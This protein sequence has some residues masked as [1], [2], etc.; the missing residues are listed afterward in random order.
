MESNK[1]ELIRK[2]WKFHFVFILR[3]YIHPLLINVSNI[4]LLDRCIAQQFKNHNWLFRSS[5][6]ICCSLSNKYLQTAILK[7]SLKTTLDEFE[8]L[9]KVS[10][11]LPVKTCEN[12]NIIIWVQKSSKQ[13]NIVQCLN[14]PNCR[15]RTFN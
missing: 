2:C 13:L 1:G 6:S 12:F 11:F 10:K 9:Q 7:Q 4:Y 14:K 8:I 3:E 15:L 5:G